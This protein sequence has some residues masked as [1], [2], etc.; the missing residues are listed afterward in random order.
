MT[1]DN[2]NSPEESKQTEK[3]DQYKCSSCGST[4]DKAGQCCDQ[5]REKVCDCDSG[6]SAKDC[7]HPDSQ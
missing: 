6:K 4:D 1:C 5:P 3:K 2:C 7:C